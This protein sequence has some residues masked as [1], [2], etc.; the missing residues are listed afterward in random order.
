MVKYREFYFRFLVSV[1]HVVCKGVPLS[2]STY[3]YGVCDGVSNFFHD[4]LVG[5]GVVKDERH[6]VRRHV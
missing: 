1:I 3:L 4:V 6:V 2:F 5:I